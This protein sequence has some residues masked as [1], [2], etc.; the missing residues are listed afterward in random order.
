MGDQISFDINLLNAVEHSPLRETIGADT[1]NRFSYQNNHVLRT[2]LETF[3]KCDDFVMVCEA[4]DDFALIARDS[5]T[6]F[7]TLY[8][9]K[10]KDTGHWVF[11]PVKLNKEQVE[12]LAKMVHSLEAFKGHNTKSAMITNAP[13]KTTTKIYGIKEGLDFSRLQQSEKQALKLSIKKCE[14]RVEMAHIEKMSYRVSDLPYTAHE[15]ATVGFLSRFL[16]QTYPDSEHALEKLYQILMTE[17]NRRSKIKPIPGEIL[18]GKSLTKQAFTSYIDRANKSKFSDSWDMIKSMITPEKI[19]FPDSSGIIKMHSEWV[20]RSTDPSD[21]SFQEFKEHY[22]GLWSR[23]VNGEESSTNSLIAQ[24][25]VEWE[26]VH[27][28]SPHGVYLALLS[29]LFGIYGQ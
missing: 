10:T 25:K 26:K 18:Q 28:E 9:V 19:G 11:Q 20:A 21:L 23:T 17:I 8:Q 15:E 16:Q 14:N 1:Q 13:I 3:P 24:T 12:I 5:T 29:M 7:M 22:A 27:S 6:S 4:H 2:I